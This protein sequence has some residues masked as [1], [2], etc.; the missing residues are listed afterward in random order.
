MY[1]WYNALLSNIVNIERGEI[2]RERV[3]GDLVVLGK[4]KTRSN[5]CVCQLSVNVCIAVYY[6]CIKIL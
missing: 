2:E 5:V 6:V 1:A 3:K 4:E